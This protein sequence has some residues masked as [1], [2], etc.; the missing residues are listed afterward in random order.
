VSLRTALIAG[1][2]PNFV[3]IAPLREALAARRGLDVLV[4]HTGQH[5]DDDMSAA[6]FRELEIPE[7][8]ANLEV[9]SGSHAVQTG[10][11]MQAFDAFLDGVPIDMV[12]VVGD[13]NSTVACSLTAAKRSIPVAHV[14]AGLRSFDWEMPE[15]INR[16]VTDR[17]SSLLF[18]PSRDADENLKREGAAPGSIHF[19]GNVMVDT[20]LKF[21]AKASDSDV[22]ERLGL[23]SGA[24]SVLTLHRPRNV[25]DTAS[26]AS[27]L[28][29]FE[30]IAARIPIVYP[31]H[32][33]SRKMLDDAGLARRAEEMRGFMMTPP[34]GYLDFVELEAEAAFVM[35]DSG[36]VQEETTVLGVP[37]LTLRPNTERPVTI[38]N[39][40]NTLVGTDGP[41]IV[42]A[43]ERLL[44]EGP[45]V[46]GEV[47]ELWDGRAAERIA[48]I[49]EASGGGSG[50]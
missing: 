46:R 15:E 45:D 47:P 43:A 23:E 35:T 17:L 48:D 25:D 37:C 28:D 30:S 33:R 11:I 1:A 8:D 9:G 14:E 6:F 19:V 31:M 12:V 39:G 10:R 26:F 38:K 5:Y 16:V 42:R 29:A 36:G 3:K 44:G 20:L 24:Y 49:I 18:T 7:P 41:A 13:V 34:L 2:R 32:P 50:S 27:M 4:V 40:T 21:R 22:V